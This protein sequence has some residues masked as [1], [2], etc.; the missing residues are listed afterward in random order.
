MGLVDH[1]SLLDQL[2]V[3]DNLKRTL[4]GLDLD[5]QVLELIDLAWIHVGVHASQPDVAWRLDS[6]LGWHFDDLSLNLFLEVDVIGL[7]ED[8]TNLS[9]DVRLKLD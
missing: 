9:E 7:S 5:T 4:D 2:E 1:I 6:G 3:L 8:E